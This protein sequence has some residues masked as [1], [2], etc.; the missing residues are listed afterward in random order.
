[1][2]HVNPN[3]VNTREIEDFEQVEEDTGIVLKGRYK[4]G[5]VVAVRIPYKLQYRT[6]LVDKNT[7]MTIDGNGDLDRKSGKF[8]DFDEVEEYFRYELRGGP[9]GGD[10][11][12]PLRHDERDDKITY[13]DEKGTIQEEDFVNNGKQKD[14]M[15]EERQRYITEVGEIDKRLSDAIEE[16]QKNATREN[17]ERVRDLIKEKVEIDNKYNALDNQRELTEKT[18]ENIEHVIEKDLDEDDW[19]P[20]HDER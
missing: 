8:Y 20:N 18:K 2:N 5:D 13:I 1:M 16:Y 7:G 9:D 11:G 17:Y 12:T 14:M 10:A 6:F 4:R 19:F 15:K 3:V